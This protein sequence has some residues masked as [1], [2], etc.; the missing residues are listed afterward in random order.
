MWRVGGAHDKPAGRLRAGLGMPPLAEAAMKVALLAY[1][2][3][4][5]TEA[6]SV[7]ILLMSVMP[8]GLAPPL[9]KRFNGRRAPKAEA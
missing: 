3:E 2:S 7:A 5:I 4:I 6:A 9:L 1:L 8:A